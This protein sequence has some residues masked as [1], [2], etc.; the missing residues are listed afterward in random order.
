MSVETKTLSD[1][2]IEL[3]L[4]RWEGRLIASSLLN[5]LYPAAGKESESAGDISSHLGISLIEAESLKEELDL[6]DERLFGLPENM[7]EQD[8]EMYRRVMPKEPRKTGAPWDGLP[9]IEADLLPDGRVSYTLARG[10]LSIFAGAIDAMLQNLAPDKSG[11]SR[12][13]VSARVVGATIEEA[14][15]LRDELRQAGR[16]SKRQTARRA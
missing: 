13:E 7:S 9:A 5:S 2:R 3:L 14:E 11:H 4:T 8:R 1:G 15:G 6:I 10:E 12:T 16:D